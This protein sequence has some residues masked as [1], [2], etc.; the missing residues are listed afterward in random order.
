[1]NPVQRLPIGA[2]GEATTV[3]GPELTVG[4]FHAHMPAV[5]GTPVGR[6]VVVMA[7]DSGRG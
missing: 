7:S 2:S 4:H 1:M 3:V 5:H 6:T